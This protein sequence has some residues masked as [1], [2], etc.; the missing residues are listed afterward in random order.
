MLFSGCIKSLKKMSIQNIV[1][2][3]IIYF[4]NHPVFP[5]PV[6][7]PVRDSYARV[8]IPRSLQESNDKLGRDKLNEK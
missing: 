5:H 3:V 8:G 7:L 1:L 2:C 4:F 6:C